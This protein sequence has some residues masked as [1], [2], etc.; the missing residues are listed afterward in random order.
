[1]IIRSKAPL[2]IGL[3]GGGTDVAPYSDIYGGSVL[4][5]TINRFVYC[6]IESTEDHIIITSIDTRE[7]QEFQ[8]TDF[9]EPDKKLELHKGV[10]NRIIKDYNN[11]IPF[12]HKLIT[13]SDVPPGS[14]LGSSSTLVVAMIQAYSAWL[15]LPLDEYDIALLAY[16]IEREDLNCSGGKQDQYAA[17]FGGLNIINFFSSGEVEVKPIEMEK[18]AYSQLQENL[19]L[20]Y[21]GK[22]RSASDVLRDQKQN[23]INE[24]T[25]FDSQMQMTKL[26]EKAKKYL[27]ESDLAGFGKTL[28]ENWQLKKSLSN[29]ISDKD[30]DD[31]YSL[32]KK[33]GAL[34]GKL[35]G[36]GGGGF[37]LFYCRKANQNT[38]R[39]ALIKLREVRFK[40]DSNGSKTI[41]CER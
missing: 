9:L 2:R 10:Y 7:E 24:E 22:T 20:F 17:A 35:L 14:G 41:Y 30:I 34:G 32:A 31:I 25:K 28:D 23:L 8:L 1:M 29:K 5:A 12:P 38:L 19:L 40:F 18:N 16:V 33:N 3:A 37:L 13:Y 15:K 27:C 36:A 26:V 4:N 11:G 6:T 21:T 39:K